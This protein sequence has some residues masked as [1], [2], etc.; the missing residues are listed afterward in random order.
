MK[1]AIILYF[2]INIILQII[3]IGKKIEITKKSTAINA[4]LYFILITLLIRYY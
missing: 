2:L 3:M 4:A 1:T